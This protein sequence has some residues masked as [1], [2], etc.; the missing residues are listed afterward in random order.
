MTDILKHDLHQAWELR[1]TQQLEAAEH[2]YKKLYTQTHPDLEGLSTSA[3]SPF[4]I[5]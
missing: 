5:S 3:T 1:H 4:M 2:I